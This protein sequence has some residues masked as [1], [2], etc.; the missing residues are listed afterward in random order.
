MDKRN[1]ALMAVL[2]DTQEGDLYH[3]IYF[4]IIKY[5]IA[6]LNS[7]QTN[8][9]KYYELD[10]L[11][12]AIQNQFGITIPLIVLKQSVIAVSK[13]NHDITLSV[14]EKGSKFQIKKS[15]DISTDKSLEHNLSTV[16]SSFDKLENEFQQYLEKELISTDKTFLDFFSDNTKDIFKYLDQ[17]DSVP[18]INESYLHIS[19]FLLELQKSEQKLFDIANNIFWGSVISAFLERETDL[20]IKPL[21]NVAYYLD[22]SLVMALLDL[23]NEANVSYSREMIDIIKASGNT[24]HV[25]PMTLKEVGSILYSV[26]MSQAPKANTSIESAYHRRSLTPTIILQIRGTLNKT[27]EDLGIIIDPVSVKELDEIQLKYKNNPFVKALK[28]SRGN[29]YSDNIRDIHDVFMSDFINKKRGDVSVREKINSFFVSLNNELIYF[30]KRNSDIK[31]STIIHPSKIVTELWI[32]NSKCTMLKKNGL[33]EIMSRCIALNNTDVRRKLRLISKYFD[34]SNYTQDN[35][36]AL[37]HALI[38]RSQHVLE[39]VSKIDEEHKPELYESSKEHLLG[40]I[41]I[42]IEEELNKTKSIFTIQ[43]QYE[44]ISAGLENAKTQIQ[45]S[46]TQIEK[47]KSEAVNKEI[48]NGKLK[49]TKKE[50]EDLIA[51]ISNKLA[52]QNKIIILQNRLVLVNTELRESKNK[53]DKFEKEKVNSIK[54][55]KFHFLISLEIIG[56]LIIIF[57]LICL[58]MFVDFSSLSNILGSFKLASNIANLCGF[59]ITTFLVVSRIQSLFIFTPKIHYNKI[60]KEQIQFWEDNNHSYVQ[61]K[62]KYADLE[63]ELDEKNEEV[64]NLK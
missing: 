16:I 17:L 5:G 64:N 8:T 41:R 2:Y 15:W 26:E 29:S 48:E 28:E 56:I 45:E 1:F 31:F 55:F 14:Y 63:N 51:T 44:E 38:S 27:I 43:K 60:R 4:P 53:I 52:E 47:S 10:D 39:E 11:Q 3:D 23:D 33:T 9:E 54:M 62:K 59:A 46:K 61:E 7:S 37:Y 35:Y 34:E 13:S 32:H 57:C 36:L 42:A 50:Q 24:I 49:N 21:N 20:Q 25:H 6:L 30:L 19:K 58:I 40:A 12:I 18:E 22:S